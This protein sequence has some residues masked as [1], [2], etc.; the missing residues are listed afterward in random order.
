VINGRVKVSDLPQEWNARM[1]QY[2]G[3]TPP[4]DAQGVLQ[5]IHW[6]HGYFGYFPDYLLG[7]IFAVQLWDRMKQDIP[8]VEAK[9]ERG[10]FSPIL[11]W[12][13][14]RI[15]Q[16]GL[17][18]TL[19]ELAQQITGGPLRWEPYMNYL[20]TKYSEVYGLA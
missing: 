20:Q 14:T 19:P 12:Q 16:H 2:L 9:I 1:Q 6:S 15:H 5:D 4:N 8:D 13:R 17:K 11:E 7:S 18:F 3:V 10:E